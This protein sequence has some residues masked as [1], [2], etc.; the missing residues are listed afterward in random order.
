MKRLVILIGIFI[1][2]IG[3]LLLTR[4]FSVAAQQEE[5]LSVAELKYKV[6]DYFGGIDG[7]L[8]GRGK[9][10]IM[11]CDGYA[12][13]IPV[14][15]VEKEDAVRYFE[16]IRQNSSVYTAILNRLN[17]QETTEFT[18]DEQLSIYRECRDLHAVRLILNSS[19]PMYKDLF[20]RYNNST[21]LASGYV[22]WT[23]EVAVMNLEPSPLG[24]LC[25]LCLT[26][27]TLID[28]PKGQVPIEA[29]NVG[30]MVIT[31]NWRGERVS[32]PILRVTKI[33]VEQHQIIHL[34]L[35]DGTT[36]D[37][38]GG[39]PLPNG[40]IVQGLTLGSRITAN[41]NY[42]PS[43]PYVTGI[44]F[45]LYKGKFTYD[46]LPDGDTGFYWANGIPLASTLSNSCN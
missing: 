39:H 41:S 22:E 37:V 27:G 18:Q 31:S 33:P 45:A 46:I 2:L 9:A 40:G 35:N 29:I 12:H 32:V 19:T 36:L 28:T 7:G 16:V 14:L 15:S 6:I 11:Y 4:Q 42:M 38:S 20:V 17:L 43:P 44:E 21:Y 26:E 34:S 1:I 30:D 8:P 25:P 5:K 23:G 10:G 13:P 3:L 24:L